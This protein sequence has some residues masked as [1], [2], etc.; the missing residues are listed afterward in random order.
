[1]RRRTNPVMFRLGVTLAVLV[2]AAFVALVGAAVAAGVVLVG[3][4]LGWVAGAALGAAVAQTTRRPVG[5][6][7]GRLIDAAG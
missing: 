6:L 3:G 7:M 5:L 1:M 2:P 4:V